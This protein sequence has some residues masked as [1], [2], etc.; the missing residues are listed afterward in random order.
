MDLLPD[1]NCSVL[2]ED[3]PIDLRICNNLIWNSKPGPTS[4]RC[5]VNKV[6]GV[7]LVYVEIELTLGSSEILSPFVSV[8]ESVY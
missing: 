6:T 2:A 8:A 7:V 4:P 3:T 5:K 1:E